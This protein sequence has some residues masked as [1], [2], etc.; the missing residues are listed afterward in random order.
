MTRSIIKRVLLLLTLLGATVLIVA[1]FGGF[2]SGAGSSGPT[3]Y[4]FDE[5]G[6]SAIV[7]HS[8]DW[9]SPGSRSIVAYINTNHT[10]TVST[11]EVRVLHAA[12]WLSNTITGQP[13]PSTLTMKTRG[14]GFYANGT[15]SKVQHATI[16]I[17]PEGTVM[18]GKG[19]LIRGTAARKGI[20]GHYRYRCVAPNPAAP[21][22]CHV[23]GVSSY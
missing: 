9:P 12:Q 20:R 16:T 23:H 5:F 8:D 17:T 7:W 3:K 18:V 6:R 19:H 13:T 4:R 14:T 15:V 2:A 10:T 21:F 22:A 1:A 11:G